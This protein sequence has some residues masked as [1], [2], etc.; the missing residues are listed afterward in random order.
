MHPVCRFVDLVQ[1]PHFMDQILPSR[2]CEVVSLVHKCSIFS[3]YEVKIFFALLFLKS[4]LHDFQFRAEVILTA[5]SAVSWWRNNT[6]CIVF[7]DKKGNKENVLISAFDGQDEDAS[8]VIPNAS[9]TPGTSP[10][11]DWDW[12]NHGF[13]GKIMGLSVAF[14]WGKGKGCFCPRCWKKNFGQIFCVRTTPRFN[15]W[16]LVVWLREFGSR[17][18]QEKRILTFYLALTFDL[19]VAS[20][21]SFCWICATLRSR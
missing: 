11:V 3:Q 4:H 2:R 10:P 19:S 14:Q 12:K 7:S 20:H 16:T 1:E 8:V 18:S 9:I 13:A 17:K 15:T 21:K 5:A 6:G